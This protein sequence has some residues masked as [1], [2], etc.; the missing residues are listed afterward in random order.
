MAKLSLRRVSE[1]ASPSVNKFVQV[2]NAQWSERPRN[3]PLR[4]T[5]PNRLGRLLAWIQCERILPSA[6]RNKGR[7]HERGLEPLVAPRFLTVA[8]PH[9]MHSPLAPASHCPT[10]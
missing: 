4:H 8:V 6:P 3:L 2:T 5:V 1:P 7:Y 10:T 9:R